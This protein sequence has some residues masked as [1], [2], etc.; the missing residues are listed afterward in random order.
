[1]YSLIEAKK[2]A[3]YCEDRHMDFFNCSHSEADFREAQA[4]ISCHDRMRPLVKI[5]EASRGDCRCREIPGYSV[6]LE[7]CVPCAAEKALIDYAKLK[8]E[9][10]V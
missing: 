3:A 6:S 2:V 9:E 8:G 4:I 1:M 10:R 7:I 5:V